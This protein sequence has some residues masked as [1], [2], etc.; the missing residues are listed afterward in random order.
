M[1]THHRL[2]E[3]C[4]LIEPFVCVSDGTSS[5][6]TIEIRL[7]PCLEPATDLRHAFRNV[8]RAVSSNVGVSLWGDGSVWML[9]CVVLVTKGIGL[10]ACDCVGL[11]Q[12]NRPRMIYQLLPTNLL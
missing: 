1:T 4:T 2:R 6:P 7:C 10:S 9:L 3:E 12:K 5:L 8:K 11:E